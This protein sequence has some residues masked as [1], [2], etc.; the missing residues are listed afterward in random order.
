ELVHG[1]QTE[2]LL[3][4]PGHVDLRVV[5]VVS[6][7]VLHRVWADDVAWA[8]M[9]VD[10]VDAV[11]RVVFFEEDGRRGPHIAVADVVDNAANGQVV[12]GLFGGPGR[13]AAGVVVDYPQDAQRGNGTRLDVI[14]EVL[15]PQIDAELVGNAEI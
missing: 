10:V 14:L 6:G 5:G 11:L 1:R 12:I 7:A 2:D 8:A 13:R 3:D 9:T 15:H 4:R